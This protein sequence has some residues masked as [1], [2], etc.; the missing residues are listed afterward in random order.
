[1]NS[2]E[3]GPKVY[4]VANKYFVIEDPW[5]F[6]TGGSSHQPA[7]ILKKDIPESAE[8]EVTTKEELLD[9]CDL[10]DRVDASCGPGGEIYGHR[11]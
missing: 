10:L 3:I 6:I 9:L 1:M 7:H 4:R 8:V 11:G 5:C 2:E